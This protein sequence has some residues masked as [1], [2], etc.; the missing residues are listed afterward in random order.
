MVKGQIETTPSSLDR[1]LGRRGP[2]SGGKG[3]GVMGK[4]MAG[5]GIS[6]CVPVDQTTAPSKGGGGK[7]GGGRELS[8]KPVDRDLRTNPSG[9]GKGPSRDSV[10]PVRARDTFI[11]LWQPVWSLGRYSLAHL[12]LS[13]SPFIAPLT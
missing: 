8:D 3:Q 2:T 10:A 9:G 13:V 6:G 7:G 12:M 1:Q 5:K 11:R 4:G